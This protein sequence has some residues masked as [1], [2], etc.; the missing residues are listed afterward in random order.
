MLDSTNVGCIKYVSSRNTSAR[1]ILPVLL[2]ARKQT[3]KMW[4]QQELDLTLAHTA[5]DDE[6]KSDG[7][8]QKEARFDKVFEDLAA[9]A[10]NPA[11]PKKRD[12]VKSQVKLLRKN[13]LQ[14]QQ[15]A[16][17]RHALHSI[18]NPIYN[19]I[20][21]VTKQHKCEVWVDELAASGQVERTTQQVCVSR[22]AK[23][24]FEVLCGTD[25]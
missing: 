7:N 1:N 4:N 14:L 16:D 25:C 6:H 8:S 20:A 2:S 11:K 17:K 13:P 18:H 19:A 24:D 15:F 22:P 3:T 12:A 23:V 9:Q 21:S 10:S 5:T